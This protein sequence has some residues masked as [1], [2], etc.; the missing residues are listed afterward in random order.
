M[1][2]RII[3]LFLSILMIASLALC[4]T[5][6]WVNDPI[7]Y[8]DE[9]GEIIG[10]KQSYLVQQLNSIIFDAPADYPY[11]QIT[12]DGKKDGWYEFGNK[13]KISNKSGDEDI[14]GDVW[15][16]CDNDTL[17]VFVEAHDESVLSIED[18]TSICAE[19]GKLKENHTGCEHIK[20]SDY[21]AKTDKGS[22]NLWNSDCVE[23]YIDKTNYGSPLE[24]YSV[25]RGGT[26]FK[27]H[28]TWGLDF[29]AKTVSDDNGW[30]AEFAIQ[31]PYAVKEWGIN[32]TIHSQKSLSPF[33]Q[34][35]ACLNNFN[36][37]G[38]WDRENC[39]KYAGYLDYIAFPL[40]LDDFNRTPFADIKGGSWYYYDVARA[41]DRGLFNGVSPTL[42]APDMTMTR[43]MFV[44]TL[45]RMEG[46]PEVTGK[47]PFTDVKE[48]TYYYDAVLWA[49]QN[50]VVN[51][52]SDNAFAPDAP[53]TREQLVAI[54]HR[55]FVNKGYAFSLTYGINV[56]K[57]P[58]AD[59]ISEYALES[60]RWAVKGKI[61]EGNG[62]NGESYL[63]P[64]GSATR[65]QVAAMLGRF[66]RNVSVIWY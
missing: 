60:M 23:L 11:P 10:H 44:T 33:E 32:I 7:Q 34:T 37:Y 63:D 17:Y 22:V 36:A 35:T 26:A 42:F 40:H 39:D 59:K 62:V 27:G 29:E 53:L 41:I 18:H 47:L 14:Y 57:Y 3:S 58:D 49:Y 4:S 38:A 8:R 12:L 52:M 24:I 1:T 46:S 64:Q 21:D 20:V 54:L 15:F 19:C 30:C 13:G 45:Y 31:L 48:G 2:K 25:T 66:E 55:Y 5:A 51:G 6:N 56:K 28:D 61:I 65:A 9:K 43:A 16:I 50:G